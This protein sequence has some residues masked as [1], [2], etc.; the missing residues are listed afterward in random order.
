MGSVN[1]TVEDLGTELQRVA[2]SLSKSVDALGQRVSAED[3]LKRLN[4]SIGEL[5][6]RMDHL[7]AT[8][9]SLAPVLSQ[10]A[11]PLELRLVPSQSGRGHGA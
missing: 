1:A 8:Q 11:Q 2:D 10:L 5:A 6:S 9:A 4:T 7:S 3:A